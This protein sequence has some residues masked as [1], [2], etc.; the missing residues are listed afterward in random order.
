M[1]KKNPGEIRFWLLGLCVI[2]A[3]AAGLLLAVLTHRTETAPRAE[4]ETAETTLGTTEPPTEA[5]TEPDVDTSDW[6]LLLVNPWSKVPEDFEVTLKTLPNGQQVDERC[7]DDLQAMLSDCRAAG[8]RPLVCSGYRTQ[9]KQEALYENKVRR[10]MN[11]GSNREEAMAIAAR[12][13]AFPGTSEH[14]IGLAVDIVDADYV[15]LDESQEKM[16]TQKWLMEHSWEYGLIL[17]YPS[18]KSDL[19]GIIYEPWHYR[20]VGREA[21]KD[22]HDRG[23]CLEE[24]LNVAYG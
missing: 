15:V 9:Q 17:R 21:A 11:Q 23:V 8:L 2:A 22:I 18:E 1:K 24:Y 14:Q 7:Y 10:V 19:T 13:V 20:Y 5:P 12:E 16:A 4:L 6:R 3:V